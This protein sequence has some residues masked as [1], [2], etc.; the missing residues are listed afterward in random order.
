MAAILVFGV[1]AY[2]IIRLCHN[3]SEDG[4]V[5]M[6]VADDWDAARPYEPPVMEGQWVPPHSI[7]DGCINSTD[8]SQWTP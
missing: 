7:A 8:H 4:A 3:D 2:L 5:E 6:Y 1:I